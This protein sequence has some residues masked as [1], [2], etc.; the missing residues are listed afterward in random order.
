MEIDNAIRFQVQKANMLIMSDALLLLS[1]NLSFSGSSWRIFEK[2]EKTVLFGI[3][4][5]L[6]VCVYFDST[7]VFTF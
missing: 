3:L 6:L 2:R 4:I 5:L 1:C 7:L